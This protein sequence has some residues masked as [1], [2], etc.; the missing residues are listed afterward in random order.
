[1]RRFINKWTFSDRALLIVGFWAINVQDWH[2]LWTISSAPDNI[3][4]VRCFSWCRFSRGWA[5][6]RRS[7]RSLI[8]EL[9][10]IRNWRRRIIAKS[11]RGGRVGRESYT[12]GPILSN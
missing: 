4:I 12:F 7:Q 6:G 3:P 2:Q 9:E 8:D 5:S 10:A 1:M 11:S